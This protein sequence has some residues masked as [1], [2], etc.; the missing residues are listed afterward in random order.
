MIP[1]ARPT[2]W[3]PLA[4]GDEAWCLLVTRVGRRSRSGTRHTVRGI[5]LVRVESIEAELVHAVV[6][7]GSG[8]LPGEPVA[9]LRSAFSTKARAE[10][11]A[12]GALVAFLWGD[13]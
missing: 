4:P 2:S 3:G 1:D 10:R 7:S 12:F 6:I 11:R 5:A 13:R 9:Y 8:G